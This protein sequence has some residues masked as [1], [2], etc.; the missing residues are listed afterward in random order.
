MNIVNSENE[1]TG[2]NNYGQG[3]PANDTYHK[4]QTETKQIGKGKTERYKSEHEQNTNGQ[5]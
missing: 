2:N 1:K 4:E 3:K 5:I